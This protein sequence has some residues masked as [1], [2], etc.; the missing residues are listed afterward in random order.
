[1]D[2]VQAKKLVDGLYR[3]M[4]RHPIAGLGYRASRPSPEKNEAEVDPRLLNVSQVL[5]RG[6][7]RP[8]LV[9]HLSGAGDASR[10]GQFNLL[11]VNPRAGGLQALRNPGKKDQTIRGIDHGKVSAQ[12][13]QRC[14]KTFHTKSI[15]A[16]PRVRLGTAVVAPSSSVDAC[17]ADP[18]GLAMGEFACCILRSSTRQ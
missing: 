12:S 18:R 15:I 7:R 9:A 13:N 4:K 2:S 16:S 14:Q 6:F 5:C 3:L 11:Q 10:F 17:M 8:S 1:M